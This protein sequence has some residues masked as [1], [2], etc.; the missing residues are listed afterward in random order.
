[1]SILVLKNAAIFDGESETLVEGGS[2][3]IEN[4]RIREITAGDARVNGATVVDAG[5]RFVMPGLIDAH[6]HAYSITFNMYVLDNMPIPTKVAHAA[7]LLKGTLHRGYTTV[8][9]PAGGEIGLQLAINQGLMEGPRY[10]H[11]GK[12]LSQTGGHGDMRPAHHIDEPCGC[13][14]NFTFAEIVDGA[15]AVRAFCRNE[16]RKGAD[17]IKVFISGGV[18]S[19]TDP[20][21]MPQYTD[22]E[23]EAAV[24]EASTR[25][26]YV[27]AHCH[28][29][30]GA[31]RC[32]KT[33]VR[34]IDHCTMISE[35]TAGLIKQAEGK[36]YAVPTLAVM[37]Q[38]LV[39]GKELGMSDESLAKMREVHGLAYK[40][41]EYLYRHGARLGMGT[42]LFGEKYHDMQNREFEFRADIV[43]PIDLLRSATSINAEI[44]KKD[45]LVGCL[46][47]GAYADLLVVEGNPLK[48]IHLMARP[49][50]SFS[51]IMKGG[52]FI[53]N[54]L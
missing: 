35:E 7:R 23:I 16:L 31:R 45:G 37:E 49:D 53:R 54:R 43:K 51:V 11:G 39:H 40:S 50:Q 8:R 26:K 1:M 42:D 38:A 15:D 22:E 48:D 2:I 3:V 52:E 24:Y 20:V 28:T 21:W 13:A 47:P 19:P 6:F 30:D 25:R 17:H 34:S 33:G 14:A 12:A 18:A 5:G 44:M 10:F 36:T 41:L 46:K 32:L 27:V 4:D 9:D 29:D